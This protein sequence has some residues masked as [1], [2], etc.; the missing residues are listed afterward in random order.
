MDSK[1]SADLNDNQ[2]ANL[3]GS[4]RIDGIYA[5][6]I[7]EVDA[8]KYRLGEN[9]KGK[10]FIFFLAS[11]ALGFWISDFLVINAIEGVPLT[12][13]VLAIFAYIYVNNK[14]QKDFK[15]NFPDAI[16]MLSSAI[17]AGESLV[18]ALNYVAQTTNSVVGKE[19]KWVADRLVIGETPS[20]VFETAKN[21]NASF[22]EY[23]FF[24]SALKI[25]VERGGQL[26]DIIKRIDRIIFNSYAMEKKKFAMTS[27][28][29]YSAKI[30][31]ALPFIFLIIMRYLSPENFE[32]VFETETG[33]IILWYVVISEVI[34]MGIIHMLMRSVK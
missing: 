32:Y 16:N 9:S 29:R 14:Y 8:F 21:R 10:L 1:G 26:S 28:A 33:N 5:R 31:G 15:S 25:N 18:G 30:V 13:L 3:F 17:K 6:I 22:R 24:L 11:L 27:E 4:G 7:H 19:L 34:G 12:C 23:V 20:H 2:E